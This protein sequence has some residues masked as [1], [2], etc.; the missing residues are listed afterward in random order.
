MS[1]THDHPSLFPTVNPPST[2]LP[3]QLG[4]LTSQS[5]PNDMA[6]WRSIELYLNA[7]FYTFNAIA[8]RTTGTPPE[9]QTVQP[10]LSYSDGTP[11]NPPTELRLLQRSV[12]ILQQQVTQLQQTSNRHEIRL[13]GLTDAVND[14]HTRLLRLE[15]L[16]IHELSK[17][18]KACSS[19]NAVMA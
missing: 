8:L 13:A 14:L 3:I 18:P 15:Q 19:Y 6:Y 4:G 7:S 5:T 16:Q 1:S 11:C 9:S 17:D 10:N 12:T 2:V